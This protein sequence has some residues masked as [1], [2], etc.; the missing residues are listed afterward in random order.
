MQQQRCV[1]SLLL[2]N[3]VEMKCTKKSLTIIRII[4][5]SKAN[6]SRRGVWNMFIVPEY[7]EKYSSLREQHQRE[8]ALD[9]KQ[10]DLGGKDET[11]RNQ[12]KKRMEQG[13]LF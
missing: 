5:N 1:E 6:K 13:Q 3:G 8:L 9:L 11:L 10:W 2:N 4:N 7:D 12:L